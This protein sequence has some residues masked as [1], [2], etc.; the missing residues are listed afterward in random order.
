MPST[1]YN[2]PAELLSEIV[3]EVE[4]LPVAERKQ[5][6]TTLRKAALLAQAKSLDK[7]KGRKKLK[8]MTDEEADEFISTQR[9]LR[10]EQKQA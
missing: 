1:S 10:Y 6:L 8:P 3:A 4:K 7:V 9:R 5:L 2:K